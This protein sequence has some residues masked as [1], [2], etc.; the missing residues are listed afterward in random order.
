MA[1]YSSF[2]TT[3]EFNWHEMVEFLQ[4]T[5]SE[6]INLFFH[7]FLQT[8]WSNFFYNSQWIRQGA[9][10][11]KYIQLFQIKIVTSIKWENYIL[12]VFSTECNVES[13]KYSDQTNCHYFLFIHTNDALTSSIRI[14]VHFHF[15][16]LLSD[17][18]IENKRS[19]WNIK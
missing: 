2:N 14:F 4:W 6:I 9:K 15:V 18:P 12:V 19:I 16:I 5:K 7:I 17:N 10:M 11:I 3:R 8:F 1:W 13:I